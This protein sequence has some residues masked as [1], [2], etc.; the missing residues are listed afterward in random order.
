[1]VCKTIVGENQMMR[2]LLAKIEDP[3]DIKDLSIAQKKQLCEEIR[4]EM[5]D[6]IS[7]N[8]GHLASNLGVVELTVALMSAFDIPTDSVIFDVGHQC[9]PYKLLTGRFESFSTIRKEGGISG[10]PRPAESVYDTFVEG[11]ASTSIA[12]AIGLATAKNAV[13]NDSYTI[14][15][16]GDGALTGG[17]AFEAMNNI[18]ADLSKLVVVLNDNSMSISKSVGRLSQY[19]MQLRNSENYLNLKDNVKK[20]IH[21]VPLL[22]KPAEDIITN[23]KTSFRRGLFDGTIFEEFGF[24]YIGPVDGHNLNDLL[25]IFTQI[26]KASNGPYFVHVITHKGKGYPLAEQNPGAYHGVGSFDL[27]KG[28]PDISLADSFS[29]TFGR[30]LNRI[31][32]KDDNVFAVTAAM[33]YGTGLQYFYHSHKDR[34]LDVGIAEGY[35][36]CMTTGLAKGG[37]KPVF[38]VY[39]TFLQ[40][41]YDQLIHDVCLNNS[42]VLFAVDRAGFVG[43]DGETHQGIYDAAMLSSL[44]NFT[45]LSPSNYDE[46]IFWL[47]RLINMDG[48][49]A[50]RY[51]RG[52]E[53]NRLSGYKCSGQTYDLITAENSR[54]SVLLVTYGRE[55]ADVLNAYHMLSSEGID[56]DVMKLNVISPLDKQTICIAENYKNVFFFEEGILS[57]GIGEQFCRDISSG[58][59]TNTI[60]IDSNRIPQA[61]VS[62]QLEMFGLDS[63][64]IYRFIKEA[65]PNEET[66]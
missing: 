6:V 4:S 28:N 20:I 50:I 38:S 15:I 32:D 17:L 35:A 65:Y 14:S 43:D 31:A 2:E 40:R 53:D 23:I 9:Y 29:N 34:F 13:N 47:N 12:Q 33:K 10:F 37:V 56:V 27:E 21:S 3:K 61:S 44:K 39:S 5:I 18:S 24:N 54:K 60:A 49:K 7:N 26:S 42:N 46:L 22:G 19:L 16:I 57:G 58:T 25:H 66:T 55:F 62:R 41:C 64:S 48:P 11:H 1:M 36:A 51:P 8:G 59:H 52:K 63:N 30:E 45:V